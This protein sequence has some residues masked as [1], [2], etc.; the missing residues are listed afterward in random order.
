MAGMVGEDVELSTSRT[1]SLAMRTGTDNW[2]PGGG[3][4]AQPHSLRLIAVK[5]TKDRGES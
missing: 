3:V 2:S 4:R 1:G 5:F